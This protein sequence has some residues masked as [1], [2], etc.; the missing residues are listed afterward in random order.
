MCLFFKRR[1]GFPPIKAMALI[2][3]LTQ[4][5][6]VPYPVMQKGPF[7]SKSVVCNSLSP[8]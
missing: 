6:P 8:Y 2:A 4:I 1:V 3:G 7:P 5:A